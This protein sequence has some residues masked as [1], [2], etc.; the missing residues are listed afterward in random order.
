MTVSSIP[1]PD[2]NW[3]NTDETWAA[4]QLD[5]YLENRTG[6]FSGNK[7]P[8]I[9]QSH[10]ESPCSTSTDSL[11]RSTDYPQL[12][13]VERCVFA[14]TKRDQRLQKHNRHS[15]THQPLHPA[16]SRYR[17]QH[18]RRLHSPDRSAPP[19]LRLSSRCSRRSSLGRLYL[20]LQRLDPSL[21][22]RSHH[23]QQHRSTQAAALRL[24]HILSPF[25]PCNRRPSAKESPRVDRFVADA[26]PRSCRDL[27]RRICR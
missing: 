10:W 20:R 19:A 24:R 2:P 6:E 16:T 18:P 12:R 5:I 21:E 23:D 26:S 14:T 27:A 11:L 8:E 15:L 17:F 13:R 22:P 1:F 4:E 7:H 25:G 3:I 9:S